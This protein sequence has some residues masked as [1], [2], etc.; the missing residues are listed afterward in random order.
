MQELWG[1]DSTAVLANLLDEPLV[2]VDVGCR[3]GIGTAWDRL[4]DRCV[5]IGFDPDREECERLRDVYGHRRHFRFEP[6]GLG[7]ERRVATLYVTKDPAGTS[8][9]PPSP[10]AYEHHP[11][12]DGGRL[13]R[14]TTVELTTLEQWCADEGVDRIDVL[15]SDAQGAELDVLLG[16]GRLLDGVRALELEVEFNPLYEDVPLFGDIDRFLR[17]RGFVLWRLDDLSHYA[18][19]DRAAGLRRLERHYFEPDGVAEFFAGRGQLYWANAFY[20]HREAARPDPGTGWRQLVRDACITSTWGF[21]DLVA[22]AVDA[23]RRSAPS[24]VAADL[25]MARSEDW[26]AVVRER[27]MGERAPVLDGRLLVEAGDPGFVG[28]GWRAPQLFGG[29]HARWSGPAREASMDLPV[30]VPPGTRIE[31]MVIAGMSPAIL[32]GV[33]LEV[34][35]HPLPLTSSPVADGVLYTAT[36]PDGYQPARKFTR[37]VV[38]TPETLPWNSVDTASREDDEFGVALAWV[39]ATAPSA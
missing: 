2:V 30:S 16:A 5:R 11:A 29:R 15:K 25:S 19:D 6:V 39:R 17:D 8:L 31:L 24:S 18:Q 23:A 34:N 10:D 21:D 20:L 7:A 35:R 27:E 32:A 28:A 37:L 14:T 12:L 36:V 3:W 26:M 33:S 4:G 22:V 1:T 9:Y 38:R 13:A